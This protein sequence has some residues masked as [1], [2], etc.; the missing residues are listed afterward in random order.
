VELLGRD[1]AQD[2]THPLHPFVAYGEDVVEPGSSVDVEPQGPGGVGQEVRGQAP[3]VVGLLPFLHHV[4]DPGV[5]DEQEVAERLDEG[6]L[7]VHALFDG[8]LREATSAG[9]GRRPQLLDPLPRGRQARRVVRE[10]AF[11][12]ELVGSLPRQ[13]L[14]ERRVDLHHGGRGYDGGSTGAWSSGVA[15]GSGAV[16]ATATVQVRR[17]VRRGLVRRRLAGAVTR[18]VG[19]A[20]GPV[21]GP[22]LPTSVFPVRLAGRRVALRELAE[23][24]AEAF[25]RLAGDPE[26]C[27]FMKVRPVEQATALRSLSSRMV[28]ARQPGRSAYELAVEHDGRFAGTVTLHLLG[29]GTGELGFWFLPEATGQ[30]LATDACLTVLRFGVEALDLHRVHA[31]CDVE[32]GQAVAVLERIGM[33][34]E[35]RMRHAVRTHL[36]WR[37]RLLYA[38]LFDEPDP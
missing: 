11:A 2:R 27:R 10:H 36:G 22:E 34:P 17:H 4:A 23:T 28:R 33:S 26:V 7:G 16:G 37:D 5:G 29:T 24:D 12:G 14:D 9:H 38:R 31:T 13:E 30:G 32:N 18:V 8:P 35:G 6:P 15:Y 1:V 25:A 20:P 19:V 3:R 21:V